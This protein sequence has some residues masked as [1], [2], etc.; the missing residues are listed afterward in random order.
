[1]INIGLKLIGDY[2]I[3]T[4]STIVPDYFDILFQQ[5]QGGVWYYRDPAS[6]KFL[7]LNLTDR[8]PLNKPKDNENLTAEENEFKNEYQIRVSRKEQY[9][10]LT[11]LSRR[12]LESLIKMI[13]GE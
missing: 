13:G 3:W 12:H 6:D 10:P 8:N 5:K 1:M 9:Q 7:N 11:R 4:T 2:E